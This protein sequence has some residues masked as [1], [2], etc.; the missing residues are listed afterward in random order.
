MKTYS[1]WD[2]IKAGYITSCGPFGNANYIPFFEG[3]ESVVAYL[4]SHYNNDPNFSIRTISVA[5][6]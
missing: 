1:I 4:Q 6:P 2:N 5:K 3:R